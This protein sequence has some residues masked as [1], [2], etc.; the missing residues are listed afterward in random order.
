MVPLLL[1]LE[2]MI[3]YRFA[4]LR[5]I[6]DL[7]AENNEK[8]TIEAKNLMKDRMDGF[9][10]MFLQKADVG[11]VLAEIKG[12]IASLMEFKSKSEGMASARALEI[13]R[14]VAIAGTVLGVFGIILRF[15][16][17]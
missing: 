14:W 10:G 6:I 17:V 9:P 5:D 7:Q 2:K 11:E 1:H 4:G 12:N 3:D 8:S 16:K 15:F 13:V